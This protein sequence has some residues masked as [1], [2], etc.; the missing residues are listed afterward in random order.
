MLATK[1]AAAV[2]IPCI[3]VCAGRLA[4]LRTVN[5]R[6]RWPAVISPLVRD[7]IKGSPVQFA[8][9]RA[10]HSAWICYIGHLEIGLKI[11]TKLRM[12]VADA[13]QLLRS[14]LRQQAY[15]PQDHLEPERVLASHIGGVVTL[16]D[17][18]RTEANA[19]S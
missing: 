19:V 15:G 9:R 7:R 5:L 16:T 1:S 11:M 2:S 10:L 17:S 18:G 12:S 13:T 4:D 3:L 14:F 6:L 8:S